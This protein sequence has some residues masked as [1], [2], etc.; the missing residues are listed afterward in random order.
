M[1]LAYA[2]SDFGA[3]RRGGFF[4]S[5]KTRFIPL[6]EDKQRGRRYVLFL[7]PRRFGK[8]TLL[9]MLEHYYDLG[10]RDQFDALFRGLHVGDRPTEERSRYVILKLDF[11]GIGLEQGVEA[12]RQA[13]VNNLRFRLRD[14]L[15]YYE[16]LYP[17]LLSVFWPFAEREQ[18]PSVLLGAFFDLLL[19]SP[20]PMYILVDEYDRLVNDLI[21]RG[22]H[23]AYHDVLA[24]SGFIRLMYERIKSAA[25]G[26]VQR[27]FMTGI[28]PVMLNDMASGF[29]IVDN[30]SLQ[31]EYAD[32][33]GFS[34]AEVAALLDGELARG[35]YTLSREQVLQD[36]RRYYN[37]YRF[38]ERSEDRVYNPNAVL[39]FLAR[40]RP[41]DRYPR[42]MLDA[43]L[44]T[45]EQRLY[46]LL[47]TADRQPRQRPMEIV[48]TL[49]TEGP[50]TGRLHELFP[51]Q[52]AYDERYFP[53]YLY[54]LG[55]TTIVGTEQDRLRMA[56]PNLTIQG[57]HGAILSYVLELAAGVRLS[58]DRVGP[59]VQAMAQEGDLA[60]FLSLIDA[61]VVQK[62]SNRDLIRL[63]ERGLKML[64]LAYLS[65]SEVYLPYSEQEC[66]RGYADL[67][68]IA[69]RRYDTRFSF[70][71]ELKYLKDEGR[72]DAALRAGVEACFATAEEQL[73]GY[74][75]DPRLEGVRARDGWRAY[76]VVQVGT[77]AI[78]YRQLGQPT[79]ELRW[80]RRPAPRKPRAGAG[81]GR[82][83]AKKRSARRP[84]EA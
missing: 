37:G 40:L 7:R 10:K 72:S 81:K 30:I 44:R 23:N 9:S 22:D 59:C 27:V 56:I 67:I 64:L 18:S 12:M 82:H 26:L 17:G 65:M 43:N 55:L 6:L 35:G 71:I 20:H 24:A 21:A 79:Q 50:I 62:L 77:R 36:L 58:E 69:D 13:L 3:I 33:C 46:T 2:I 45:D 19:R 14:F 75:S 29:N 57:V 32:L 8:T 15:T 39:S 73:R 80:D 48:R 66:S 1:N 74:L 49:L 4:Y 78:L 41:P 54:Y 53:S 61:Q 28:S 76:S 42:E 34:Q 11:S 31:E 52:Q 68:L 16:A 63:D 70:L 84:R 5:D 51:L 25:S 47:F 60:P 83:Q 38:S